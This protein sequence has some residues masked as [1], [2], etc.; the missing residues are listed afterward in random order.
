[1]R[2][3]SKLQN[4]FSDYASTTTT[5]HVHSITKV[6]PFSFQILI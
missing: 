4:D 5:V 3:K 1:M 6:Y 2:V